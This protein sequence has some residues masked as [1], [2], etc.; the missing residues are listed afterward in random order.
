M[1][2]SS[3]QLVYAL[4]VIAISIRPITT[5]PQTDPEITRDQVSFGSVMGDSEISTL[6][7][8]YEVRPKA[9]F[10]WM[11]G[12]S[13]T[14]R[15]NDDLSVDGIIQSAR[16]ES[17]TFLLNSIEAHNL[18]LQRFSNSYSSDQISSDEALEIQARSLLNIQSQLESALEIVR[19]GS[20]IIYGI[21]VSGN[22]DALSQLRSSEHVE[23]SIGTALSNT[24]VIDRRTLKPE[25]YRREYRDISLIEA[26][27]V[28]LHSMMLKK[29]DDMPNY[30]F[31]KPDYLNR[32]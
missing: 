6:I 9:V 25:A 15:V 20:P 1:V 10:M 24:A 4:C 12:L 3:R 31:M 22:Q 30:Y 29:I 16:D 14:H 2:F 13:A 18:R 27:S 8:S 19:S 7:N 17:E 21:E 28:E 11:S 26:G 5:Y 32:L 23:M